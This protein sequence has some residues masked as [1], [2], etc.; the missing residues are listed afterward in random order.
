MDYFTYL[1]LQQFLRSR[2]GIV[3]RCRAESGQFKNRSLSINMGKCPLVL[4]TGVVG[5][6]EKPHGFEIFHFASLCRIV[7]VGIAVPQTVIAGPR[8]LQR[9]GVVFPMV[10]RNRTSCL[11]KVIEKGP[12]ASVM[13]LASQRLSSWF[14]VALGLKNFLTTHCTPPRKWLRFSV[15]CCARMPPHAERLGPS[16]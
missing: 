3:Y 11:L 16:D 8:N 14:D 4:L 2:T 12:N 10:Q 15:A 6:P 13:V 5:R 9:R 7:Q 1:G